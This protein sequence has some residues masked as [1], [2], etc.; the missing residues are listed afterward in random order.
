MLIRTLAPEEITYARFAG[1]DRSQHITGYC[2]IINGEWQTLPQER[3][4]GWTDAY[5]RHVVDDM[6]AIAAAGGTVPAALDGDR[7][8]GFTAVCAAPLGSRAQYRQLVKLYVDANYRGS[9][10][11]K[12]LF[13]EACRIAREMGAEKLYISAHSSIETIAWY[14]CMGCTEAAEYDAALA[15]LEPDDVQMEFVL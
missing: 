14:R 5:L 9:G 3:D 4:E 1:F 15:A 12:T 8:A 10:L 6:R 2:H 7:I 13:A 11:G